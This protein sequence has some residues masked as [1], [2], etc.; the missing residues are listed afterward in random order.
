MIENKEPVV[1]ESAAEPSST[2]TETD[3]SIDN[4]ADNL[5]KNPDALNYFKQET[6]NESIEKDLEEKASGSEIWVLFVCIVIAICLEY[7]LSRL[8]WL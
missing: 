2:N 7:F 6:A 8:I 3:P 5:E 1:A 4:T